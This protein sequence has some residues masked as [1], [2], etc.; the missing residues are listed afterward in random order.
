M[1]VSSLREVIVGFTTL[2][3][4]GAGAAGSAALIDPDPV[5]TGVGDQWDPQANDGWVE[6]SNWVPATPNRNSVLARSMEGDTVVSV[7]EAGTNGWVGSFAPDTDALLYQQAD[8]NRS[9]LML[10]DL[11]TRTRSRAQGVNSPYWEWYPRMSSSLISFFRDRFVHGR[12]ETSMFVY[13]R[14]GGALRK[15]WT[16]PAKLVGTNN[17]TVGDRYA[18][19]TL[20]R[21]DCH[22]FLYD[23]T[24]R[25]TEKVPSGTPQQYAPVIDEGNGTLYVTVGGNGCGRRIK[26]VRYPLTLDAAAEAIVELPAGI[27]TGWSS[28][29]AANDTSGM[30]DLWLER[31]DCERERADVYVARGVDVAPT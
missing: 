2:V 25:D 13:K 28:S 29:I 23:W 27:D 26:V 3:I 1:R 10:F 17:G 8:G 12:W 16:Y 20:C 24:E 15:L 21:S 22:A 5:V 30:M 18:A 6:Y 4:I 31:W 11:E 19:Y 7:K 14:D 9:D